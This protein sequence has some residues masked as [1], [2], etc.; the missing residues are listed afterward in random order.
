[1]ADTFD[2]KFGSFV[3]FAFTLANP[4]TGASGT[5]TFMTWG[6]NGVT[7]IAMPAAG[8]VVALTVRGNGNVTGATIA[9][10]AQKAGTPYAQASSILT[11][12][13]TAS[14]ASNVGYASVR[15]G[16]LTFAAGDLLGVSYLTA[17]NYAATTVDYDAIMVVQLNPL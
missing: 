7:N 6:A 8:S 9:F 12:L 17:T 1:M 11:T 15:S 2:P 13:T 16:V 5:N 10:N 14:G 3:T 4:D